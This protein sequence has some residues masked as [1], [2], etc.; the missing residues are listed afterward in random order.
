MSACDF[1]TQCTHSSGCLESPRFWVCLV[2][3]ESQVVSL[4]ALSDVLWQNCLVKYK[5]GYRRK[6]TPC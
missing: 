1:L 6:H 4:W 3:R 5:D 2:P